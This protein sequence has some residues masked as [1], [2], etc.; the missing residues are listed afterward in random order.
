MRTKASCFQEL[1]VLLPQCCIVA[2]SLAIWCAMQI[3]SLAGIV[4][5]LDFSPNDPNTL[6][7][8]SY[9]SSAAVY[10]VATGT[11]AFI[12]SGH[13]GGVTQVLYC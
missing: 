1:H 10:D 13:K 9:S 3:L 2:S 4:S 7:A 8:G 6:A 5:C 12:L 11:A